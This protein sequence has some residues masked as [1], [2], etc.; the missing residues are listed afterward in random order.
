MSRRRALQGGP[1]TPNRAVRLPG[2]LSAG[3]WVDAATG[4]KMA[5]LQ[6]KDENPSYKAELHRINASVK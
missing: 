1:E 6:S 5:G 4:V 2:Q 3:Q